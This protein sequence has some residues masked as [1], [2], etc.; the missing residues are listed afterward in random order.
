MSI[1]SPT[2]PPAI[3]RSRLSI[4]CALGAS[5]AFSVNDITVR[6]FSGSFPLHEV[7]L[8]R[9]LVA[10]ALTVALLAPHGNRLSV[11][12]TRRIPA[13]VFR[14]LCVVVANMAYFAAL[15][16]LPMAETSAIFFVAPLLITAFS[17]IL[18]KEHVG[19]RRWSAL[20]V[21]MVGVLLIVKPGTAA[22]QWALLLPAI[23]AVAYASLHTMTRSMGLAESA[24]T[25]AVYIQLTFIVVCS[26]MGLVFGS[27]QWAGSGHPSLEFLFRAWVWP[28]PRDWGL[29]AVA[30]ACS[31]TGSYL[32]S[33]AY[34]NSAAA[35]VAPFEYSAL[36][37]A[38]FWGF[39]IWGEI[40]GPWSGVGIVL[41]LASGLFVAL[42]EGKLQITPTAQDAAGRR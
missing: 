28:A 19:M 22:F 33:Q 23:S 14:G 32:I 21:G 24:A 38:A 17:A 27:G 11:F 26:A 20:V 15:A 10:L 39:T 13:H 34:R 35:L 40:P 42:R 12:R 29:L 18:L 37:L 3:D 1:A 2:P 41:V 30:G 8:I 36:V 9:A 31:A 25:M 4:L 16:T 6:S 7:V 5:L